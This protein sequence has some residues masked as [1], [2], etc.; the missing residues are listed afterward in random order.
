MLKRKRRYL[1]DDDIYEI[2]PISDLSE[3][4]KEDHTLCLVWNPH[5]N[6]RT[7]ELPQIRGPQGTLYYAQ[8]SAERQSVTKNRLDHFL[9]T[10]YLFAPWKQSGVRI[11]RI[12]LHSKVLHEFSTLTEALKELIPGNFTPKASYRRK[13]SIGSLMLLEA[14]RRRDHRILCSQLLGLLN[15]LKERKR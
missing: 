10:P 5:W 6:R 11:F 7:L 13:R 12:I 2:Q 9:D 15:Y 8:D 1:S 3:L 4:L 14:R